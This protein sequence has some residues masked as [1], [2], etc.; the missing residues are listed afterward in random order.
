MRASSNAF[1]VLLLLWTTAAAGG[2][3][4]TVTTQPA[5][6]T[7]STPVTILIPFCCPSYD[8]SSPVIRNGFTFDIPYYPDCP[9][10]C[11]PGTA[12]YNVGLLPAGTYTVRHFAI[13]HPETVE[14]IGSFEVGAPAPATVPALGAS[15]LALLSLLL[16]GSALLVLRRR[17]QG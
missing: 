17:A 3:P 12:T 2:V 13:D 8:S 11:L 5:A 10:A 15:G 1:V 14:V 6:P 9:S 4:P 7:S 16:V